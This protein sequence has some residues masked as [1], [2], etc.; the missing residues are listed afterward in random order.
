MGN[1]LFAGNSAISNCGAEHVLNHEAT[2]EDTIPAE[3]FNCLTRESWSSEK[4]EWCCANKKLGCPK[5]DD[6]KPANY[7]F[8]RESWSQEKKEW[9]C[10]NKKLGCPKEED[11]KPANYCFTRESWSQEKKEWCCANKKLG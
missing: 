11:E 9:C 5:E 1:F 4:K 2:T 3:P 7:C 8:T 6:E 10:A